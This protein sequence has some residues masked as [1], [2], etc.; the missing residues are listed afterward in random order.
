MV[1]SDIVAAAPVPAN[2]D[3]ALRRLTGCTNG[4]TTQEDYASMLKN[5]G[6]SKV[7]IQ[8]KTT[9][10]FDVL[11]EKAERKDR[12][13]AFAVIENIPEADGLTGSAIIMATRS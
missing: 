10:T 6:F 12:M 2:A 1:I 9:Y 5:A 4:I 13:D 8:P 7:S 11:R 3:A